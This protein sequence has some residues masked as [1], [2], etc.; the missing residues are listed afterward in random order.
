MDIFKYNNLDLSC[1]GGH[2][3]SDKIFYA[4]CG[5]VVIMAG[6]CAIIG[7]SLKLGIPSIF[8]LWLLSLGIIL[9]VVGIISLV[10]IRTATNIQIVVGVLLVVVS[11]GTLAIYLEL[12]DVYVTLAIIVIIVGVCITAMGMSK[13]R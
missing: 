3:N 6:F 13:K 1:A 5:L 10:K 12:L 9:V 8:M 11:G 2:M 7:M 4:T